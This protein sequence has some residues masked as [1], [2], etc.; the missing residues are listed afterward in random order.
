ME[1]EE[2][3]KIVFFLGSP[4]LEGKKVYG[5]GHLGTV[6]TQNQ[7]FKSDQRNSVANKQTKIKKKER[8]RDGRE[9]R[10]EGISRKF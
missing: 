1:R 10:R 7:G 4:S 8:E 9:G 6:V 5:P 3:R 2:V